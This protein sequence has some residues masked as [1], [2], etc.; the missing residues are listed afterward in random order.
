MVTRVSV[1][2]TMLAWAR[3]RSGLTV[4]DLAS[5]F[6]KLGEWGAGELS[7][8]FRQLENYAAATHTPFGFFFLAALSPA[9]G[10]A[11]RRRLRRPTATGA[12]NGRWSW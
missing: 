9:R 8:T 11:R 2:P 6:P 7:P 4:E 1:P 12:R 5:K 3:S 10:P